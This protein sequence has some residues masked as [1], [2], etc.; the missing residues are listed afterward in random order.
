[1]DSNCS[2]GHKRLDRAIEA[3]IGTICRFG[4]KNTTSYL[5]AY[6]AEMVMT[7]IPED[8]RLAGLDGNTGHPLK[9]ARGTCWVQDL[10]RVRRAVPRKIWARRCALA[11]EAVFHGMGGDFRKGEECID[12][13][14]GARGTL[15]PA[16]CWE[17]V[18]P[19][20]GRSNCSQ[21]QQSKT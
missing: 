2:R 1:M 6:Q 8:G 10:G 15:C 9:D 3:I 18:P 20:G 16:L 11:I 12:A 4:G 13:H 17:Y 14:Q 7:D 21:S 19:L 5:E